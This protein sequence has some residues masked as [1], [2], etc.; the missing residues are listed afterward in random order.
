MRNLLLSICACTTLVLSAP[1]AV[2][3]QSSATP[4]DQYGSVPVL[5]G[6]DRSAV[7]I[8]DPIPARHGDT[9]VPAADEPPAAR[10]SQYDAPDEAESP[11]E[12]ECD[13]AYDE[14]CSGEDDTDE[15]VGDATSDA[16]R[17]S[18]VLNGAAGAPAPAPLP[19][20]EPAVV[21]EPPATEPSYGPGQYPP[22]T[23]PSAESG[24]VP[25]AQPVAPQPAPGSVGYPDGGLEPATPAEPRAETVPAQGVLSA[26]QPPLA[27]QPVPQEGGWVEEPRSA[28]P[29]PAPGRAAAPA[30]AKDAPEGKAGGEAE[31]AEPEPGGDRRAVS[32]HGEADGGSRPAPGEAASVE[33]PEVAQQ[34]R[35]LAAE[36]GGENTALTLGGSAL[37]IAGAV[38]VG[39]FLKR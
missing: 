3:A 14:G 5:E 16:R 6:R 31:R 8:E 27:P 4:P 9:P 22:A 20:E 32:R 35:E 17:T 36:G 34:Q 28:S 23:A 30:P 25:A 10:P 24:A 19:A 18:D 13:P 7:V 37:L 33:E 15:L 12:D 29:G 11:P 1:V 26:S 39:R 38:L 21:P 2:W